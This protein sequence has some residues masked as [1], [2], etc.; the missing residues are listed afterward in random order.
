MTI[1]AKRLLI[2]VRC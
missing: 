2:T 1:E